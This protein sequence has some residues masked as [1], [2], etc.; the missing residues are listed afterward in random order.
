[1]YV[2]KGD[3]IVSSRNPNPN[4]RHP[5][6]FS[7]HLVAPQLSLKKRCP[8]RSLM[9]TEVLESIGCSSSMQ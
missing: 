4:P 2:E 7:D 8:W 6:Y 3:V 5:R 9:M 1:M